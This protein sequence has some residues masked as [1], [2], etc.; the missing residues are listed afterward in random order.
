MESLESKITQF[1]SYGSGYGSGDGS[2][3]G[4]GCGSGYGSGYD[5]G[6]G[7]GCGSGHDIKEFAGCK[8]WHVDGVQT[9][10]YSVFSNFAKGAILESD[11]TLK[12]CYMAKVGNCFAH[13]DT[14][15]AAFKEAE[16]KAL[17]GKPIEERIK[18]FVK[19][20]KREVKYIGRDL[21][22]WHHILTG[23]C[24]MG[25]ESFCRQHQIDIDKDEFFVVDFISLTQNAY[26]GDIIKQLKPYYA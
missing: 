26:G 1:L 14:L 23:S 13:A 8:V 16:A 7:S 24:T 22:D 18:D 12:D 15:K 19:S 17:K 25:R 20:H 4:L 6:Y 10:I 5:L 9:L 2:G 21:F 11:L 3:D